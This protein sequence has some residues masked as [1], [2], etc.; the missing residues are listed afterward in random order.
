MSHRAEIGEF[1]IGMV[2]DLCSDR[3]EACRSRHRLATGRSKF[4]ENPVVVLFRQADIE[5]AGL[6]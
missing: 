4:V 5:R 2:D 1:D 6:G 3:R